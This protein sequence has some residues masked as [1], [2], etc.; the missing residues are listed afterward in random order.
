[1]LLP[2]VSEFFPNSAL[3]IALVNDLLTANIIFWETVCI[4]SHSLYF[5]YFSNWKI[6]IIGI[7]TPK[8]GTCHQTFT[9]WNVSKHGVIS[10][11]Y[12]PVFGLNTEKYWPEMSPFMKFFRAVIE[13]CCRRLQNAAEHCN[14]R[15]NTRPNF[16][17][18]KATEFEDHDRGKG[19]NFQI[20][21]Q[22]LSKTQYQL[23]MRLNIVEWDRKI[24]HVAAIY[25]VR[26]CMLERFSYT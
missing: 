7:G 21:W 10:G 20:I 22:K 18:K 11:P 16:K 15:R 1:M 8:F 24:E 17:V 26:P 25:K 14:I 13:T 2:A 19:C 4:L 12:F 6:M 9:A 5:L 3:I 23:N